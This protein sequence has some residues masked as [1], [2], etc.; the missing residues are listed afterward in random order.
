[1]AELLSEDTTEY[2]PTLKREYERLIGEQSQALAMNDEFQ[3]MEARFQQRLDK[4]ISDSMKNLSTQTTPPTAGAWG[5]P[6]VPVLPS[7]QVLNPANT[8]PTAGPPQGHAT[9]PAVGASAGP[10][11]VNSKLA[12]LSMSVDKHIL[13]QKQG[14]KY[15]P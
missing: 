2:V 6:T 10:S 1:M 15:C 7:Q 13:E 9:A 4:Q 5:A 14:N 12:A 3:I 8:A 11:Q